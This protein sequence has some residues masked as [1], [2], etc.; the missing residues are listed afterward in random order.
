MFILLQYI[1][2]FKY[3]KYTSKLITFITYLKNYIKIT[4]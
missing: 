4:F 3:I 1:K 2:I